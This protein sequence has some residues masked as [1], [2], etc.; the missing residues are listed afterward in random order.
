MTT[1][2]LDFQAITAITIYRGRRSMSRE[3]NGGGGVKVEAPQDREGSGA[4]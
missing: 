3:E 1:N 2:V 4:A